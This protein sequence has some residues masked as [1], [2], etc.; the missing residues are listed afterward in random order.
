MLAKR[1]SI[2]G[3]KA[4]CD[5]AVISRIALLA[6]AV[7]FSASVS[8][9]AAVVHNIFVHGNNKISQQEIIDH[10]GISIN[11]D[12][13]STAIDTAVKN[14]FA[15]GFFSD[16]HVNQVGDRLI[17]SVKEYNLVNG[18]FFEG[19]KKIPSKNLQ[20]LL[21]IKPRQ[22]FNSSNLAADVKTI[23]DAYKAAG[24]DNVNVTTRTMNVGG[25]SVNVVFHIDETKELKIKKIIFVGNNKFS[26]RRLGE[27]IHM[28]STGLFTWLTHADVYNQDRLAVDEE[29]LRHFYFT[30]GYADFNVVSAKAVLD[31]QTNSYTVTFVLS[32]GPKYKFG[33]IKIESTVDQVAVK[34]LYN[35]VKTRTG[36]EYNSDKV[37]DSLSAIND[38]IVNSGYAF[39]KVDAH[40]DHDFNNKTISMIYSINRGERAYI[41]RIEVSGN[42]KTKDYV[43][44]RE[45]DLSEGDAL[46]ATLIRRA[47]RR[48]EAL[49]FFQSVDITT[50]PGDAPDQVVLVVNVVENATGEF[51]VGGG[52]TTGGVSPGASL[53]LSVAENNFLGRGQ[54]IRVGAGAGR[55]SARN[56]NF[57]FTEPYFFGH[58][59]PVGI[60]LFRT[61]YRM[62]N[63][64]GVMEMGGSPRIVIPLSE[65]LAANLSYNLVKE[66]YS[67]GAGIKPEA[68]K[69]QYA[70]AIA[71]AA[72]KPWLRSS[73][74]YGLVYNS[75]DNMRIPRSGLYIKVAQEFAGLGG[76]AKYLKTYG[77]VMS[78]TTLSDQHDI[79]GLLS[80]GAG[81]MHQS[82]AGGA[83]V[84]DMFKNDNDM[85]RGF[86]YNGMGPRQKSLGGSTYFIGG[87]KYMNATAELQYAIPV[88]TDSLGMRGAVFADAGTVYDNPY[89]PTTPCSAPNTPK[90]CEPGVTNNKMFLRSSVGVSLMW[91]SPIG[92]LRF[93]YAVPI[94]KDKGDLIEAFNF[95]V[96]SKF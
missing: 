10:L 75:L 47:K 41:E 80:A 48:L 88:L 87:S 69:Q 84:F 45:F 63:D 18:V 23:K 76:E 92:P 86:K 52:Y 68:L 77:K 17:V 12:F 59:L 66:R 13:S 40:T 49:G 35:V 33:N 9:N 53:D 2:T 39:A 55:D 34:P 89:L 50:K 22:S 85:V 94:R 31:P 70:G 24:L 26:P 78:Y 46:N 28:Q 81:F 60:D 67:L 73:L 15:L 64:Y 96:S 19:N 65:N 32:E 27:V 4:R 7:Y 8:S 42:S 79:I 14:L 83:R 44:R 37:E 61:T 82:D 51:S 36:H 95:G 58:R 6:G 1:T 62:D 29:A 57:S 54:Y 72:E 30:H 11:Q 3:K 38:A 74:A 21:L 43:V 20:S 93:D 25:G 56:F 90:S 16:V 91:A 71:K 5:L